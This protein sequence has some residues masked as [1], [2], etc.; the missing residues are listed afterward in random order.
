MRVIYV[1]VNVHV[2]SLSSLHY[3]SLNK[4]LLRLAF[5]ISSLY[6]PLPCAELSSPNASIL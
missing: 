5:T 3:L 6:V 1:G 2:C 4:Q